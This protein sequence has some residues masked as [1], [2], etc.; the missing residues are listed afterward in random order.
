MAVAPQKKK[1][2]TICYT[3]HTVSTLYTKCV[4]GLSYDSESKNDN[5]STHHQQCYVFFC[6]A[7]TEFLNVVYMNVIFR[8]VIK[9]VNAASVPILRLMDFPFPLISTGF[10]FVIDLHLY[11]WSYFPCKSCFEPR[12]ETRCSEICHRFVMT[13]LFGYRNNSEMFALLVY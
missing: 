4:Y 11:V 9:V 8:K 3:I 5:F 6:E 2:C 1:E 7:D 10:N 13:L 12:L